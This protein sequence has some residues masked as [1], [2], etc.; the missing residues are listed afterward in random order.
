MLD[1]NPWLIFVFLALN[2]IENENMEYVKE[3]A[4]KSHQRGFQRI[5]KIPHQKAASAGPKK[6]YRYNCLYILF[7]HHLGDTDCRYAHLV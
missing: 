4:N 5:K 6:K 3:T 7:K 2:K 1:F